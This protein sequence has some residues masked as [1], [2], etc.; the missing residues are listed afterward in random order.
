MSFCLAVDDIAEV[1]F[2]IEAVELGGFQHGV[3][4]GGTLATDFGAEE[5]MVLR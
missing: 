1:G 4:D 3:D 5:Q 2:R